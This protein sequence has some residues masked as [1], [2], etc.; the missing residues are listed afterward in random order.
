MKLFSLFR[1]RQR[2]AHTDVVRLRPIVDASRKALREAEQE[3]AGLKM[4]LHDAGDRAAFLIGSD[5]SQSQSDGDPKQERS[6]AE[7]EALLSRGERRKRYLEQQI[8]T[9]G[10]VSGV[11][12]RA[13]MSSGEPGSLGRAQ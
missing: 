1:S 13:I 6:L 5:Y 12:E 4:R 2:D 10:G 7:L 9:L 11:L 3:L 8:V